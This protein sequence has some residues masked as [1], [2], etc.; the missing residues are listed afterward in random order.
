MLVYYRLPLSW[1]ILALPIPIALTILVALAVGVW[2]AAINVKY[3]DVGVVLPVVIQLWMFVSPIV[4]PL[5]L[6]P[7][8]W[9]KLYALNPLVGIL[10]AFRSALFGRPLD[11]TLLAISTAVTLPAL[12]L[13]AYLFRR[14]ERSFADIV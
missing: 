13:A 5:S 6:I 10:E 9:R 8:S 12:A 14:M 3:R 4:Y 7:E 11:W 1:S 2:S